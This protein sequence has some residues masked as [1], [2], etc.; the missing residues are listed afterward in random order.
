MTREEQTTALLA[1][2]HVMLDRHIRDRVAY[3]SYPGEVSRE[4]LDR[5][6]ASEVALDD[7]VGA[8]ARQLNDPLDNLRE[9]M[10]TGKN[11]LVVE[12]LEDVLA[13]VDPRLSE[14]HTAA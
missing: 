13:R 12:L 4:L 10:Q 5:Q 11:R 2:A 6:H 8:M 1:E 7:I 14:V 3:Y 9:A